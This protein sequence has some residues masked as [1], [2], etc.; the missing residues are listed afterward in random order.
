M[1]CYKCNL[2][3]DINLPYRKEYNDIICCHPEIAKESD[4]EFA[5]KIINQDGTNPRWCPLLKD[6]YIVK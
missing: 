5:G 2:K 6:S 1:K 4:W 3:R